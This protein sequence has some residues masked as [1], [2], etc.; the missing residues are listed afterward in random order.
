MFKTVVDDLSA[1]EL[2][3]MLSTLG[4]RYARQMIRFMPGSNGLAT[5]D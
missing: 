4:S 5:Q 2:Q 1:E 3:S